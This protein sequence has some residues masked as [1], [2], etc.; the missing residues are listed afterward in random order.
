MHVRM[1]DKV[2]LLN[3][4]DRGLTGE[5]I[6]IDRAKGRVKVSRRNMI[7]K[8][9]KPNP[10]LGE[11][12]ARIDRENWID[13]SNVALYNDELGGPERASSRYVGKDNEHFTTKAEAKKSFGKDAPGVIQKVRVGKKSGHVYDAVRS[14]EPKAD[15]G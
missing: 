6:A 1:N 14:S 12:G 4:K 3:G 9:K 11:S 8:H 13:A 2:V 7:V 15:Q 5:V 10:L